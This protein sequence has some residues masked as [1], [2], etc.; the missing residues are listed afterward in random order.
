[1]KP[2]SMLLSKHPIANV[3]LLLLLLLGL[4]TPVAAAE[5]SNGDAL[6]VQIY[7]PSIAQPPTPQP[8]RSWRGAYYGN[9]MLAGAPTLVRQDA[10]IEF[11][12]AHNAPDAALP[13]DAFSV[14]W[15]RTEA[16][17]AGTY[18]FMAR[19]TG[20]V[21]VWVDS[22]L[23]IDQWQSATNASYSAE[24]VLQGGDHTL[25]VEYYKANETAGIQFW[26]E[27]LGELSYWQG[28]YYPNTTLSG[29]PNLTRHDATLDFSWGGNA[30]DIGLPADRFSVR[31]TR[32]VAFEGGDYRFYARA[33]DGVRLF[34]DGHLVIDQWRDSVGHDLTADVSLSQG[35]HSLR[36][37]YYENMGDA[38]IKVWWEKRQPQPQPQPGCNE[39]LVNGGFESDAAWRMRTNPVLAG[40]VTSPVYSGQRSLRT[41]IPAGGV[42]VESYSPA[43]QDFSIPGNATTARL[44]FWRYAVWGDWNAVAAAD[45]ELNPD[46]LPRTLQELETASLGSDL[47]YVIA[48]QENGTLD[49]LWVERVDHQ[50]WQ[51]VTVDLNR[52]IGKVVKL[53]FGTYNNGVG[54]ISRTFVDNASVSTCPT[55]TPTYPDWK[56]E[57]YSNPTL[58]GSAVLVRNDP[59]LDFDWGR[60]APAANLPADNF[61]VRWTRT[62]GFDAATY[63]F[64]A[65]VDDGI[66]LWVDDQL[67]ID[68]WR[69]GSVREISK[70][71]ALAA[72]SH[73]LRIEYLELTEVAR[74]KVRW[75]KI[76]AQP[77][78]VDILANGGFESNTSWSFPAN[79]V[80]AAYA[81][82]P[83]LVGQRSLRTGVPAGG[84][85]LTSYSPAQQALTIPAGTKSAT[86]A[87]SRYNV[88]GDGG[89]RTEVGAAEALAADELDMSAMPRTVDALESASFTTDF[90]Y[91]IGVKDDGAIV[92]LLVERVNSPSWR[93]AS[94]DLS[95]LAGQ[96]IRLQ[97]GTYNNGIGGASRT[98][99]DAA[100]LQ[101]CR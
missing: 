78:C 37:E 17:T 74:I 20:G 68:D 9:T 100:S 84:A 62:A 56:G 94:L 57:Y 90:F 1:M 16:F 73:R 52:Y 38:L 97:F 33:D 34:V 13:R 18:R 19:V 80:P 63:R 49:W 10:K 77:A 50:A 65:T 14:R 2:Q 44:S 82:D 12:W 54:G 23:L 5:E 70:D 83:V 60:S 30:P 28:D 79:P 40:Y 101:T 25:R 55:S 4:C 26:W 24:Y 85:N 75:E 3:F 72:G 81:T 27:R 53:Q 21:R 66:R 89:L 22:Q 51:Y 95:Q 29:Q 47:F 93:S 96:P 41:G 58:S 87:F 42:N 35:I 31:W 71:I 15:D 59:A 11:D 91:V 45:A 43:Q 7:L 86:L 67:L 36:V 98:L 8:D 64:H 88:W 92:W 76:Q 69:E 46:A 61:S 6:P 39:V 99:V 32:A 48:I